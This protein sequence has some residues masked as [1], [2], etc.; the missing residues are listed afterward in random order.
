[1]L[2]L[3]NVGIQPIYRTTVSKAT[4][5]CV[6]VGACDSS[7]SN[8]GVVT[9]SCNDRRSNRHIAHIS[10]LSC[11]SSVIFGAFITAFFDAFFQL[12]NTQAA[13]V[14]DRL[15][16]AGS[17]ALALEDLPVIVGLHPPEIDGCDI[18]DS[19]MV[20]F[21]YCKSMQILRG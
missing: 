16:F 21:A 4:V 20:V 13:D 11:H 6:I 14:T 9:I 8:D 19:T 1:M 7:D 17:H 15:P 18:S 5:V 12:A 10:E 3:A 2:D